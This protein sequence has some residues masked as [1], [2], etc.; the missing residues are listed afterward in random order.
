MDHGTRAETGS[1]RPSAGVLPVFLCPVAL[2]LAR[3]VVPV[4]LDPD[5]PQDLH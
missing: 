5:L 2:R 1:G 4:L 3:F